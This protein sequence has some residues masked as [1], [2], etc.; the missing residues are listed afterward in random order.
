MGCNEKRTDGGDRQPE[1][2]RLRRKL[3]YFPFCLS[4]QN[5]IQIF[6]WHS[7]LFTAWL[8]P[9]CLVLVLSARLRIRQTELFTILCNH[10]QI[11]VH[12]ALLMHG[13]KS[14]LHPF[15]SFQ[16]VFIYFWLHWLLV[17]AQAFSS[18]G[19]LRLLS[20]AV[21]KVLVAD[22]FLAVEHRL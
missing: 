18:C 6:A 13:S 14:F 15:Q 19:E 17:A 8:Q 5:E 11:P 4:L 2:F 9:T 16:L 21:Y 12:G 20:A 22:P 3:F 7:K 1:S 10:L